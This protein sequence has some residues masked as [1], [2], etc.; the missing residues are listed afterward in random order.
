[1]ERCRYAPVHNPESEQGLWVIDGARQMVYAQTS[2][3]RDEQI[4]AAR[5][6]QQRPSVQ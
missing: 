3:S 4:R 6:L 5:K 1:M 2:L